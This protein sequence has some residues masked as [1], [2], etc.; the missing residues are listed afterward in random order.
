M[1]C[2]E[3]RPEGRLLEH[4]F[5]VRPVRLC[6]LGLRGFMVLLSARERAGSCFNTIAMSAA[7]SDVLRTRAPAPDEAPVAWAEGLGAAFPQAHAGVDRGGAVNARPWGGMGERMPTV[8]EGKQPLTNLA[9][10]DILL[11]SATTGT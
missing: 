2:T 7:T 5:A 4:V 10:G 8:S 6:C 11:R 1:R 3:S 9:R